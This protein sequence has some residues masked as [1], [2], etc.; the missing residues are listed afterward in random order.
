MKK[1][2]LCTLLFIIGLVIYAQTDSIPKAPIGPDFKFADGIFL[3]FDMVKA[4]K[5][6]PKSRIISTSNYNDPDFIDGIVSNKDLSFYD[7]LGMKQ[8]IKVKAIWGY[9]KNGS[10]YVRMDESFAKIS[11]MGSIC[12]FIATITLVDD[13]YYDPYYYN[14]YYYNPYLG[15]ARNYKTNEVRQFIMDFGTGKIY[16]FTSESVE[17]LLMK[18]PTL[19]DEYMGL[20][21][22]KREQ[23]KFFYIRKFNERN[24][25]MV[26]IN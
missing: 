24:P 23:L 7:N 17:I 26:P 13:R 20:K 9:A 22:R 15:S 2:F 19:Y 4:N 18:D 8:T 3:N 12:H 10:L 11:Y 21:K 14:P 6:I 16:D 5:P 25:L 1:I